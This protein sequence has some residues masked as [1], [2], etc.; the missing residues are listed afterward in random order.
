MLM[1]FCLLLL[2]FI[3]L[4]SSSGGSSK[5]SNILLSSR[6]IA[7]SWGRGTLTMFKLSFSE[8]VYKKTRPI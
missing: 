1:P 4:W 6:Y 3:S 2:L 7:K 5:A 8:E